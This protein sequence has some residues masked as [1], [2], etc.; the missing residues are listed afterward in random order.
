V[1]DAAGYLQPLRT[2]L[3]RIVVGSLAVLA[4]ALALVSVYGCTAL[5]SNNDHP[6]GEVDP[7][8]C[9]HKLL[10]SRPTV[11]EPSD[12]SFDLVFARFRTYTGISSRDDAGRPAYQGIGIDLD[13]TCTGEGQGPSC[14]EPNWVPSAHYQDGVEGIDNA[15]GKAFSDTYPGYPDTVFAMGTDAG[16][17]EEE[18]FRVRGYS[19][20]PDDDQVEV[21]LYAALGLD[22]REDG[23]VAPVWDGNDHWKILREMLVPPGYDIDEPQFVDSR[24]YVSNRILVAQFKN[25]L[26]PDG[27]PSAPDSVNRV[28]QF[29]LMGHLMNDGGPWELPDLVLSRRLRINDVLSTL[30]RAPADIAGPTSLLCATA[31]SYE[32]LRRIICSYEDITSGADS[33]ASPCDALSAGTLI[34]ARQA[35]LGSVRPPASDPPTCAPDVQPDTDTCQ[36]LAGP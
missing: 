3:K 28:A 9:A 14:L 20:Q 6:D 21:D 4:L 27:L 10:P 23:G 31:V 16:S 25:V 30:A 32:R 35:Q 1:N 5:K 26:W 13:D 15:L 2:V 8:A 22:P 19:G 12:A 36:S 24:A 7:S 18:I 11:I 34:F 17:D 33:V 29:T